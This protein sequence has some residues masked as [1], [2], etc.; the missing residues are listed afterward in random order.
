MDLLVVW[1][2]AQAAGFVFKP[3]LEELSKDLGNI[4]K[5]AAKDWTKDLFKGIPRNAFKRLQKQDIED[6]KSVV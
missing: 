6:R 4:V 2:V 1:G 5:D 3:I